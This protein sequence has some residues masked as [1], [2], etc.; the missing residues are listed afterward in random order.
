MGPTGSDDYVKS[1]EDSEEELNIGE[2]FTDGQLGVLKRKM[3]KK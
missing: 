3:I 2:Y 1:E